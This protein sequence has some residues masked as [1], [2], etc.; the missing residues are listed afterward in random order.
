MAAGRVVTFVVI[1]GASL[2]LARV[3]ERH[4]RISMPSA[5]STAVRPSRV[6]ATPPVTVTRPPPPP[7]GPERAPTP[8]RDEPSDAVP[9]PHSSAVCPEGMLLV[10]GT[11]CGEARRSCAERAP[12]DRSRCVRYLPAECRRG[13]SLRFC[14]D[15]D[16]Y[17]NI[18]GMLP[19]VMVTFEQA[20][21][22]CSEEDKRLCTE[23]EWAF[24]CEGP[25]GLAFPYGDEHDG[26]ACNVGKPV[27]A[28]RADALWEARDVEAVV[29]RVDGRVPTG[30]TKRCTSPFG[31]RDLVG[32][33]EE[34]VRSDTPGIEAALRGGEYTSEPTCRSVRKTGQV[35][36]RQFHTG[37]RCCRDPLVRAP[38]REAA[39]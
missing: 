13:L 34:W 27:E 29:E 11:T 18:E 31:V 25:K 32:N 37:F 28:V 8:A 39:E 9:D 36:F 15:R 7:L 12:G 4:R 20:E 23:T 24:A 2:A 3:I 19:A 33:V 26:A 1:L 38:R 14:V 10:E 21:S 17:P 5:V 22:A 30:V 6:P 35:A 16:E